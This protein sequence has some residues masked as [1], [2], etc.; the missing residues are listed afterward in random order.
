[1]LVVNPKLPVANLEDLLAF[2]K[3]NPN[4][5]NFGSPG[6][7]STPHLATE[8]LMKVAGIRLT[9]VPYQGMTPAMNDLIGGHIDLMIDLFGNASQYIGDGKLRLLAVTAQKRM[10][11]VP[12]VPA[13]SEVLPGVQSSGMVLQSS[14]RRIRR[15]LLRRSFRQLSRRS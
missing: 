14:P 11:E 9:H 10:P 4:K 15:R 8:Q 3:A 7:G 13:I 6:V 12:D 2:A 5:L 1:V